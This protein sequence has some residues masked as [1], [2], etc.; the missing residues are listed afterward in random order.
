MPKVR[1]V[2]QVVSE[3]GIEPDPDKIEKVSTLNFFPFF[4]VVTGI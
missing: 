4:F 1:Y 3:H 2:G